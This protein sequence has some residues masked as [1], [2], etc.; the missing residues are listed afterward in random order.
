VD[1]DNRL[2]AIL[3]SYSINTN[4]TIESSA[5]VDLLA[6][7]FVAK[8]MPRVNYVSLYPIFPSQFFQFCIFYPFNI[9]PFDYSDIP[10]YY[11]KAMK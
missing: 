3:Q 4:R 8:E 11:T 1:Q 5:Y 6:Y 9:F 10:L 2:S 7:P